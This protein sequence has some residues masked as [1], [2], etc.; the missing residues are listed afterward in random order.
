MSTATL[1]AGDVT[2]G[3]IEQMPTEDAF[4]VR[5][6]TLAEAIQ[7][8]NDSHESRKIRDAAN[9]AK[10]Y[11]ACEKLEK[12]GLKMTWLYTDSADARLDAN[13]IPDY[14]RVLGA[15]E[16][17]GKDTVNGDD[18]VILVSL[19]S[20]EYPSITISYRRKIN[21]TDK[22]KVVTEHHTTTTRSVVCSI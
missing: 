12:A 15:F 16:N 13:E 4:R 3:V 17:C 7:E 22:C 2:V 1:S 20:K 14:V 10:H 5:S 21:P 8:S 11:E 9:I 19:R 6:R 18:S